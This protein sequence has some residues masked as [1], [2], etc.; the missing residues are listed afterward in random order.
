M[1]VGD[2]VELS[3]KGRDTLWCKKFRDM[4]GIITE[5]EERISIDDPRVMLAYYTVM[6]TGKRG[7]RQQTRIPRSYLKYV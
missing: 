7:S 6:F 2:L 3:Q 5:R 4:V 1:K